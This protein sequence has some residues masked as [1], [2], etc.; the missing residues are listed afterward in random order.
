[1]S[2]RSLGDVNVQLILEAF[3]GG[4]HF[5]MAGAQLKNVSMGEARRQLIHALDEKLEETTVSE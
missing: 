5:T 3:G 4:G 2:A 1:M